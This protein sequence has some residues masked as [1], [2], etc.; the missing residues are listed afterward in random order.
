MGL[1]L[2]A[3]AIFA[4]FALGAGVWA[5]FCLRR[6]K[7]EKAAAQAGQV[8]ALASPEPKIETESVETQLRR[9]DGQEP[10]IEGATALLVDDNEINLMVLDA[11]LQ[12]YRLAAAVSV[13]SGYA[14]LELLRERTFDIIFL[15]IQMPHL[16]G[17]ETAKLIRR[18]EGENARLPILAVTAN[19]RKLSESAILAA[20]FDCFI[21]KPVKEEE[22]ALAIRSVAPRVRPQ[23]V[24]AAA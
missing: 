7:G 22:L 5:H 10:R 4:V 20:G 18:L 14:A 13:T 15:D 21:E 1:T 24:S 6:R 2:H 12:R 8:C 16:D 11:F 17:L 23:K 3:L 9:D 19:T